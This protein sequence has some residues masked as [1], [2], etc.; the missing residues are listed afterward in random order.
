MQEDKR[1]FL[2]DGHAL[3]YRA[4]YAF[5][6][7]PLINSKGWNTSAITGFVRT[8]VDLI[9]NQKPTHLAVSFDLPGGTF[10]DDWYPAYKANRD[11]QPEDISFALPWIM[12]ILKAWRIPI[13]TLARY[14]ADD[15][16]GTIAKKAEKEGY[17]VYMVTPD[18][19]YGQLV[20]PHIFVYK[21][22]KQGNEVE[23][24]GEKEVCESW[25]IEHVDQ[26][27]DMLGLQGDSVDNIPGVPGIGPKTAAKLLEDFGSV[28]NLLANADQVKGKNG[29]RLSEYAQQA[30][31]SKKLARID[32]NAPI[33]FDENTF[34]LETFDRDELSE[35]FKELEFRTL[36]NQILG[37]DNESKESS[38]PASVIR[39]EGRQ[40]SL[41]N[42]AGP[43]SEN[44]APEIHAHSIADKNIANT[45]HEYRIAKDI[46]ER[47][48]LIELLGKQ[49]AFCFDTETTH[50]D[51]N[52]AELVGLSFSVNP[53]Q[54]WYVPV[55]ENQEQA[56]SIL[57]EFKPVF[58]NPD[59]LKIGQNIKYDA[60]MLKWYGIELKGKW[61]DTMV[62][63]Y[64]IEPE[65]RH[66]MD[67]MAET[68][69]KYQ[70]VSIESLIG[71]KGVN[72]IS[73][74][75]VRMERVAE[76]AA[77]DADITLQL[78]QYLSPKLKSE[79]L[80]ELYA[81]MEEPLIKV[82]VDMEYEGIRLDSDFL[83]QYSKELEISIAQ[84]E[85][86]IYEQAGFMF[87][88][89]SPS[90]VGD[91]LF[92][93]M[94][95]PY[96]WAKT[97]TGKYSTDESK[98]AELAG[99]VPFVAD[100]MQHRGLSKLK[101]TY[102]DALPAQVNPKSGRVHTSFNQ[103]LAAT[104]RLSSNNPNLQNIP[105][106]TADGA[107]VREA[108]IPRDNN[109]F[110][111]SADYSQIELRIIAEIS[112]DEAMLEA[113]Q[114]GQDIHRATAARV[115][116]VPYEAVSNEQRRNAKTVNFSIIYGA[117][118]TNVSQQLNIKRNE[119]KELIDNYFRQYYAL[120][121]YMDDTVE[122]ARSNGY[123]KTMLGRRRYL[124][125]IDS[126]NSLA[127]S[128]A[129]RVAI[130]SPIQ[131]TAA[132]LIKVAMINIHKALLDQ[133]L[134]TKMIL[135]VHDELVFDVPKSE[136]EIVKP[137]IVDLMR[138]AIP[139]LKVPILVEIGEGKNWLE[140]H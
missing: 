4:H 101:S 24:M 94:K 34:L 92:D 65:L 85:Q 15:V 84:L 31:L 22:G 1:L 112:G 110:L 88:I 19:D 96:R 61:F 32:I 16:I 67:Y 97:K 21:P 121:Q 8:L 70:P 73:M 126:R 52:L 120:K 111:V 35:I 133:H 33:E 109:H 95:I 135:Q 76:Y 116:G 6:A 40:A 118:A 2:L 63:H 86:K 56:K 55:P 62:A 89:S 131:G 78:Y 50:I 93:R 36:A 117:G 45:P 27:V 42:E 139:G 104:G 9:N 130:N 14:E 119:A 108:F 79:G 64:L 17:D 77:E 125:D 68:Y 87:N 140:A 75:E 115:Y 90:Q 46:M 30:L 54:A 7:R 20:S 37:S 100:I 99:E 82:L 47:T 129:E 10:R 39:A 81:S 91:I 103:A 102:V 74:R 12:R 80:K 41:F 98:L 57:L 3:V 26:V 71:K 127:R 113:F 138:N 69:L 48:K 58:E 11:A 38:A 43:D 25:G 83:R 106:K 128:N 72:Q 66:N 132:D 59:I 137:I 60:I 18:K 134:D 136:L 23:I 28:E 51:A 13:L 105:I 44:L 49:E 5:I 114:K 107:R 53:H 123:I 124:R 29:E 122:F